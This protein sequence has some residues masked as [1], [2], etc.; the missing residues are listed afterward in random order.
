M[1]HN[2]CLCFVALFPL[3]HVFHPGGRV[4]AGFACGGG[5][6]GG[7]DQVLLVQPASPTLPQLPPHH[8]STITLA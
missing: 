2:L 1:M 3:L 4:V 5:G 8:P 7:G 6:G